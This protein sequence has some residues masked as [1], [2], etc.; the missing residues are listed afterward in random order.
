MKQNKI[1]LLLATLLCFASLT[2]CQ[3][4]KDP[5]TDTETPDI[6]ES[7]T[8]TETESEP[9]YVDTDKEKAQEVIDLID[10]LNENSTIEEIK[11][12][13]SKYNDLTQRQKAM[14]TNYEK[15]ESFIAKI[16]MLEA[17]ERVNALI[18][19][20]DE[21]N[22]DFDAVQEALEAYADLLNYGEDAQ[23]R[24]SANNVE[25]LKRCEIKVAVSKVTPLIEKALNLA[26][27]E[28][29]G[30]VQFT[31]LSRTI[32]EFTG[33]LSSDA[34]SAIENYDEYLST[35]N[36]ISK[37]NTV[38]TTNYINSTHVLPED[39]IFTPMSIVSDEEFGYVSMQNLG[40][41]SS[42]FSGSGNIQFATDNFPN[43]SGY[44]SIGFFVSWA[45]AG[46]LQFINN[47]GTAM[48][49][50]IPVVNNYFYVEIPTTSLSDL[51]G[52]ERSHI[53]AW[54][55]DRSLGAL[56]G[57]KITAIVGIGIDE[58]AA[59]AAVERVDTLIENLDE[60]NLTNDKV[61]E[62][63][64]AYDALA[65][66]Y[67][68]E[69]QN[70]VKQTNVEKL[71][72]CETKVRIVYINQLI[73]TAST[74]SLD[75]K[76]NASRFAL[77]A[78]TISEKYNA[79]SQ[80]EKALVDI[81]KHLEKV[82]KLNNTV[83][84]LFDD[85]YSYKEGDSDRPLTQIDENYFGQINTYSWNTAKQGNF[86]LYL[87][88][89]S[90]VNV[91]WTNYDSIG[92]YIKFS[93]KITDRTFFIPN[94]W[95][96]TWVEPNME[97]IDDSTHLYYF[98]FSLSSIT[99][100]FYA[101]TYFQVYL[102][103]SV[104]INKIEVSNLVFFKDFKPINEN[105]PSEP[106]GSVS[107]INTLIQTALSVDLSTNSGVAQFNLL[108]NRIN[109]VYNT[110]GANDKTSVDLTALNSKAEQVSRISGILYK[111]GYNYE[112]Q[113][114]AKKAD[115]FYGAI[116]SYDFTTPKQDNFKLDFND[117]GDL[118]GYNWSGYSKIGL[119]VKYNVPT[120]DLPT[121]IP[122]DWNQTWIRP[123]K[124]VINASQNLYY[125]EFD[126]SSVTGPFYADTYFQVYFGNTVS[127]SHM[128]ITDIV[129][130]K[131]D[132][133][134][135]TNMIKEAN[136][137]DTSTNMG[138]SHFTL[139]GEK[140]DSLLKSLTNEQ[141]TSI[142]GYNDYNTK[143]NNVSTSVIY[144]GFYSTNY[145]SDW[146]EMT[147]IDND[148]FGSFK[149]YTYPSAVNGESTYNVFFNG[150]NGQNWSNVNRIGI[151]IQYN[152]ENPNAVKMVFTGNWSVVS[153]S[154]PVVFDA[155]NHIYYYEFDVSMVS[156]IS[157]YNPHIALNL[158]NPTTTIRA[159]H[160]VKIA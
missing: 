60:N 34:L 133:T 126:L 138:K 29:K 43:F 3:P 36:K 12:V 8:D 7:E 135:I 130:F 10:S 4:T 26:L 61:Q 120:T 107:E 158:S 62:A 93:H 49:V 87:L 123:T 78:Q 122:N 83:G 58:E 109:I 113:V 41:Y 157:G 32:N 128:E 142:D 52:R 106:T 17:V 22:L 79:L 91:D 71:I 63:R 55:A 69:W 92:L 150:L 75:N 82:N 59:Q 25:K 50:T 73:E 108:L 129:Y 13:I 21:D 159:S 98:E 48:I 149:T 125:F 15:L 19:A 9:P 116:Y 14:V 11:F 30:R 70:K 72:R 84:V 37:F 160:I 80:E 115:S 42:V 89:N 146:P 110:L 99:G 121:F 118:K 147:S 101:D 144:N 5:N 65:T 119:F 68:I 66:E 54:L 148:T 46:E 38:L 111:D 64:L 18:E 131:N 20:L 156:T 141:L 100:P 96:Q 47:E 153:E 16:E 105:A 57:Y 27:N 134:K 104:G 95:G 154:T 2:G 74:I 139:I 114:F 124:E 56:D 81:E 103:E 28:N 45:F 151:F 40:Q 136:K 97:L 77:L 155:T 76:V 1:I 53:G 31:L 143:K 35:Y 88:N 127:V 67:S 140:I 85:G 112:N 90:L 33:V 6:T 51:E 86:Q 117:A 23:S 145:G 137:I 152:V 39:K 102:G 132:V 44:K 24:V 94:N